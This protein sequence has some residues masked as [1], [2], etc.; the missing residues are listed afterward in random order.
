LERI[1]HELAGT[2]GRIVELERRERKRKRKEKEDEEDKQEGSSGG[3]LRKDKRRL[4][5][6]F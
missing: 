2:N 6:D 1:G 5:E 3:A 4:G